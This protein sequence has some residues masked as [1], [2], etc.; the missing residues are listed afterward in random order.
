MDFVYYKGFF[1][2][3]RGNMDFVL[4]ILIFSV[5]IFIGGMNI[6]LF[7][8][9][10]ISYFYFVLFCFVLFYFMFK[11][12]TINLKLRIAE[13]GIYT[14]RIYLRPSF[15]SLIEV[16]CEYGGKFIAFKHIESF[17]IHRHSMKIRNIDS[18]MY[19]DFNFKFTGLT[20]DE[21]TEI[22]KVFTK[23]GIKEE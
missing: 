17:S 19:S 5:L 10:K 4:V 21:L 16:D 22:R 2:K 12:S 1:D 15:I 18:D 8:S 3:M 6:F 7:L 23:N 14:E 11:L 13:D 9:P 20:D